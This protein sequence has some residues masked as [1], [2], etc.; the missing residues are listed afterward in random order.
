MPLPQTSLSLRTKDSCVGCEGGAWISRLYVL[1]MLGKSLSMWLWVGAW[2]GS[3]YPVNR[4]PLFVLLP[5]ILQI[6]CVRL[7]RHKPNNLGFSHHPHTYQYN[8][9]V[10]FRSLAAAINFYFFS[11]ITTKHWPSSFLLKPNGQP[12]AY[13][14]LFQSFQIFVGTKNAKGSTHTLNQESNFWNY[15]LQ[16][17]IRQLGK[18]PVGMVL[19]LR[20]KLCWGNYYF[21]L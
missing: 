20:V 15:G 6:L 1:G 4:V 7:Y 14:L 11:W 16:K 17:W 13:I 9:I 5:C 3:V 21:F 10:N 2:L 8:P 19:M 18:M 12:S